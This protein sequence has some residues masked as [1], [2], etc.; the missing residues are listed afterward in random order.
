MNIVL[1]LVK[2][3]R[4]KFRDVLINAKNRKNLNNRTPSI[5]CS[6]CT[7]G[8]IYH[9]L[10]LQFDSPTINLYI[11]AKDFIKL[12]K[13]TYS[14][15]NAPM[16]KI[17]SPYLYPVV[18]IDDIKLFLVHY[19]TVEDAQSA[20]NRRKNRIE[21]D[22]VFYVMNDRNG[23]AEEDIAEFDS[24]PFPNKV[25]FVHDEKLAEKYASAFYIKGS[26]KRKFV[27][28]MTSYQHK[29]GIKRYYDQFDYIA[30]FNGKSVAEIKHKYQQRG[31]NG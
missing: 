5:I 18:K 23:C 2:K 28:V 12:V 20:W 21:W 22:N 25:I 13:N 26:R 31:N 17:E 30:W 9:D 15:L 14:Y 4:F 7:G 24:L 10:R 1:D 8:T 6:D 3:I 27:N 29:L 16:K 11:N 19:K